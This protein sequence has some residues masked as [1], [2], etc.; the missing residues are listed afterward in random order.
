MWVFA[1]AY[2]AVAGLKR[3]LAA[4]VSRL[5]I[6]SKQPIALMTDSAESLLRL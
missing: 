1:S 4:F 5:H 3:R 6:S 2:K